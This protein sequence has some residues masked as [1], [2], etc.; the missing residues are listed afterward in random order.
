MAESNI[1]LEGKTI[2]VYTGIMNNQEIEYILLGKFIIDIPKTD[3]VTQKTSFTGYDYL[4]KFDTPY[5]DNNTYPISLYNFLTNL[6]S[7]VGLQ[8]ENENIVNGNYQ[9]LGNPF[10]NNENRRFV[11]EQICQLCGGFAKITA[12]NKVKL[13]NL[14][15]NEKLETFD[16]DIYNS[17]SK[18][19]KYGKINSVTL[20]LS[21]IEGES[22]N[23]KNQTSILYTS[24][25]QNLCFENWELGQY[26]INNG[27][28]SVSNGRARLTELL[29]IPKNESFYFNVNN[30]NYRFVIRTYDENKRFVSSI[31]AIANNT[32]K[33]LE[34]VKYLGVTIYN[35][36]DNSN[37]EGQNIINKIQS[38]EIKPYISRASDK[39]FNYIKF[40]A[41]GE[42]NITISDNYF[43]INEVERQKTIVQLFNVLDGIEFIPYE[44]Q[45][46]GLPYME[47]GDG[48]EI[49]DT[50]DISFT[51]YILDSVFKYDGG[52]SGT[53]KASAETEVQKNYSSNNTTRQTLRKVERSVD[54]INGRIEDIIEEQSEYET[55][56]T[57]V[58][59]DVNGIK[60]ELKDITVFDREVVGAGEIKLE[61]TS[62]LTDTILEVKIAGTMEYVYPSS[63]TYPNSNLYPVG[64]YITLVVDKNGRGNISSE[65][66]KNEIELLEPLRYLNENVYDE[67]YIIEN[68]IKLTR[69]VG[70][71]NN[72]EKYELETPIESNLGEI[73]LKSFKNN[74]YVYVLEP[75]MLNLYARYLID[76]DYIETFA[77][78]VEMN[79]TVTETAEGIMT[80]VSKKVGE[81]EFSLLV[82]QNSEAV[83]YAWNRISE[84][85]QLEVVD[86]KVC[87]AIRNQ[88]NQ[89]LMTIDQ[90]GQHF[91]DQ[92]KR[93]VETTAM[94]SSNLPTLFFNVD[95]D[96][97]ENNQGIYNTALGFSVSMTSQS[98][99]NKYYYPMFYWGRVSTNQNQGV[100]VKEK[101]I[102]D[103]GDESASQSPFIDKDS[104]GLVFLIKDGSNIMVRT[105]NGKTVAIIGQGNI[106]L[107]DSNQNS[108]IEL[109][110]NTG[111]GYTLNFTNGSI[112]AQ[113]IFADNLYLSN[114]GYLSLG[115]VEAEN[116]PDVCNCSTV[117]I[118]QSGSYLYV[119]TKNDGSQYYFSPDWTSD[120][121][122]KNNIETSNKNSL[123]LIKAI[124]HYA[125]D[126]K[127]DGKHEDIG[128]IAQELENI[129][130]RLVNKYEI[131][132]ENNEIVD[133]NWTINERYIIANLTKAVQQQQEL[134]D[135]LYA[136]LKIKKVKDKNIKKEKY[137]KDF[138]EKIDV[139][140]I[141]KKEKCKL[142]K[143]KEKYIDKF[144]EEK[145]GQDRI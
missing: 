15:E 142:Q 102:F 78:K 109:Y 11:L 87:L 62:D 58:E 94:P 22:T 54:K 2:E 137:I 42:K 85:I 33:T 123:E 25:N 21:D 29:E 64:Q 41:Q 133:Y 46:Y 50:E 98:D 20:N 110:Q 132:D 82:A 128:Y 84:Y 76:N 28:K 114:T 49:K 9:V 66:Q 101:L 40:E 108:V 13:V 103:D 138:G 125:F 80:E 141:E 126:W 45:D 38:G 31:G 111:G 51:S 93:I 7:Q 12:Q 32:I 140:Y 71:D 3:E 5:T 4:I 107:L 73:H 67:V 37:T 6:C 79:T 36:N 60:E 106:T 83:K 122:L 95:G 144:K 48:I 112:S 145:K 130:K 139:N 105:L 52:Y 59:Q 118:A 127:K 55:K 104:G 65:A 39:N 70:L 100:H 44:M 19:K 136:E 116:V 81:D 117:S 75:F 121:R 72:G 115:H 134:I 135:Y 30:N 91:Y 129:D 17:L 68:N 89:L 99:G 26:D 23:L 14:V 10:T 131:V 34:N 69:K 97:V 88:N 8:L 92:N 113:T 16:G 57:S 86:G 61:E 53:T 1:N 24:K 96:N 47:L 143:V 56:L 77:T 18:N 124:P 27:N 119:T 63:T 35:P 43:L 74:T 120:A 90:E